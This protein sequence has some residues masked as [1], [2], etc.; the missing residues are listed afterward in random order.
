[1]VRPRIV[2][3]HDFTA[4]AGGDAAG[5]HGAFGE[6]AEAGDHVFWLV[7][8]VG[9]HFGDGIS[10]DFLSVFEFAVFDADETTLVSPRR[11]WR[12]P[13]GFLIGADQEDADHV[14]FIG[15]FEVDIVEGQAVQKA[16][17]SGRRCRSCRRSRR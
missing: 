14:I 11:L 16:R 7:F 2:G 9:E 17:R 6:L 15:G 1:M 3:A 13:R 8:A 4:L 10:L 5:V 12:S